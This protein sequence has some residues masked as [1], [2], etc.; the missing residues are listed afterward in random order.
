MQTTRTILTRLWRQRQTLLIGS[1]VIGLFLVA[2]APLSWPFNIAWSTVDS[3]GGTSS[4]GTYTLSGTLGQPENGSSS[5]GSYAVSGG[6]WV[7]ETSS[8]K[9]V[10]LPYI[11]R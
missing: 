9:A 2:A 6:F 4:G 10:F 8:V 3:G 1:L 5:G 11:Q 7:W